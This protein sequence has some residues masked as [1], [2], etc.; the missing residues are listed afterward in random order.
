MKQVITSLTVFSTA[1]GKSASYTFTSIDE[2]GN[3]VIENE[4]R[5]LVLVSDKQL[6]LVN[7]LEQFLLTKVGD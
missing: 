4:R 6:K 1:E 5:S 7:E 2:D 3:K